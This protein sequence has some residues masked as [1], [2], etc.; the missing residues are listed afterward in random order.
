MIASCSK[1]PS[2]S[3]EYKISS[4]SSTYFPMASTHQPLIISLLFFL[5][6][7]RLLVEKRNTALHMT[8]SDA[9][10][11]GGICEPWTVKDSISHHSGSSDLHSWK[12]NLSTGHLGRANAGGRGGAAH[13]CGYDSPHKLAGL[14]IVQNKSIAENDHHSSFISESDILRLINYIKK[15]D[16]ILFKE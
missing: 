10:L 14:Y 11:N 6:H 15:Q 12:Q 16:K 7:N 9:K 13:L 3:E 8:M 5:E 1:T 4:S 2:E